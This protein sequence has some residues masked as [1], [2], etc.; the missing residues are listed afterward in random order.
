MMS[1]VSYLLAFMAL[2]L[3]IPVSL[4]FIEVIAARVLPERRPAPNSNKDIRQRIAILVPAHNESSG[5]LP[6]LND[7]KG[8]LFA[9]DRVIV[10]ADNCTDDTAAVAAAAGAETVERNELTK[11]GKGFAL[12]FG[13]E[14][15]SQDPPAVVIF[16]DAD[17][18]LEEG[19]IEHLIKAC[20]LT[21]R[22]AQAL[23]LM[24]AP[25]ESTINYRVAEFAWLV[26]NWVRPLGLNALNFPCQ[27]MGTGMA[28]PWQVI[29]S[30][31]LASGSIVEDLK[32]GLDLAKSG[33]PPIFCT[34]ARVTSQFPWSVEGATS[35]RKRW[36]EGHISMILTTFSQCIYQAVTRKNLGLLVLALDMAIPPLS[37]LVILLVGM[38]SVAGVA[39]LLGL[40]SAALVIS[41]TCIVA[42][43]LAVF[44]SW[45]EYGSGILPPSAII[46]VAS[47]VFAK[48][49]IYRR[50]LSSSDD[51]KWTR[52]DRNKGK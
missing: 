19:A 18:R 25:M 20:T 38:F 44:A 28:F 39:V 51:P 48:L 50:L 27:L 42:F 9:G 21:H 40:S 22:P 3:A 11:P 49:P 29:R 12:D 17:C 1:F 7:I 30:V 31:N 43:I 5:I 35:Q 32:L 46:S 52:T 34:S 2:L 10:I 4:F 14:H 36:E 47:Y 6:T 16:I 15:L 23:Y 8:Q 26:K 41:S 45:T 13:L 33:S 37:L 24:R